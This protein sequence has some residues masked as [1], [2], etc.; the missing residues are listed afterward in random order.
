[1][2]FTTDQHPEIEQQIASDLQFIQNQLLD[3]FA[4]IDALILVGGFGR[5]EGGVLK[6]DGK[7]RPENDYDL[8]MI[9]TEPIPIEKLHQ[10][11]RKLANDLGVRWVHVENRLRQDLP[12][13]PFTQYVYD[14]KYGGQ[15]LCG[16]GDI[17]DKIPEMANA[18]MP[19]AEGEKLLHTR[20]WCFL[21]PYSTEFEQRE[22]SSEESFFLISQM[23]KALLAICDAHLMLQGNYQVKY[24]NKGGLFI[25]TVSADESLKNLVRWAT[26]YKLDPEKADRPD[27]LPLYKSVRHH[28]LNTLFTFARKAHRRRFADWM[29]Y[30]ENFHGWVTDNPKFTA[31]KRSIKSLL[32]RA[33]PDGKYED[34][35]RLKLYLAVASEIPEKAYYLQRC[36]TLVEK[37]KKKSVPKD[38]D[39]LCKHTLELLG[40]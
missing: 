9:T 24:A 8:E 25:E 20:L 13:L 1:M 36:H 12:T 39:T 38:W 5:S 22:L 14:L 37:Y 30:G 15:I 2:P 6:Q 18:D 21:G 16:P 28:F 29:D 26:H 3:E 4:N 40:I 32:G 31:L 23:S 7:Y 35:V 33:T 34:M 27:P 19:L 17:L 11:E 10:T